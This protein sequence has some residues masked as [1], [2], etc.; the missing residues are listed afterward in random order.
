MGDA[1][2]SFLKRQRGIA[3][4]KSWFPFDQIDYVLGGMVCTAFY[5][6]LTL[7][8]YFLLFL[9]WFLIHPLATAIGYYLRLKD[10]PL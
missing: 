10:S 7:W 8:Q 1:F 5:I 6:Q 2:R 4:G 9:L 3:P